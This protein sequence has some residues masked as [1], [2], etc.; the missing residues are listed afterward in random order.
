M[1]IGGQQAGLP[2]MGLDDGG[3]V[4]GQEMAGAEAGADAGQGGKA[5]GVVAPSFA[6]RPVIGIARPGI[7]MRRV[8][9]E[10]IETGGAA[11]EQPPGAAE[12]QRE[13]IDLLGRLERAHDR[14][15]ARDQH[16]HADILGRQGGRQRARD[17]GQAPGLDQGIDLRGDA[18][19]L[20]K[21]HPARRSIMVW[22]MRQMPRSVRRK[23]CA[24][25]TGSSPT[26]S[27]AGI[28]TPRSMMTFERRTP[29]PTST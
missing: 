23:R 16:A 11:G 1:R 19:D 29:R 22:V 17:I 8:E 25:S 15:I 5:E 24:S 12:E 7:K 21:A 6:A 3:A 26:M 14:G 28:F 13:I 9:D 27:P 4:A 10:E 2:V 18:E 20:E